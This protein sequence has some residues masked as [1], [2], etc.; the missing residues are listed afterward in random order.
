MTLNSCCCSACQ[1]TAEQARWQH[2]FFGTS[3]YLY[4]SVLHEG[5]AN[6]LCIAPVPVKTNVTKVSESHQ[7][8]CDIQ[9]LADQ[10]QHSN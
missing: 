8:P 9:L 3:F 2:L 1:L 6:L 4:V 10:L 5:H 7:Q